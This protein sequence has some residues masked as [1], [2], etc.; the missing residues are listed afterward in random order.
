MGNQKRK[1]NSQPE[2]A[3]LNHCTQF[4]RRVENLATREF[5]SDIFAKAMTEAQLRISL[6]SNG[7]GVHVAFVKIEKEKL[8]AYDELLKF[9]HDHKE[10]GNLEN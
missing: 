4:F 1:F 2:Q 10:D 9:W 8:P 6:V 7:T 3:A 5:F